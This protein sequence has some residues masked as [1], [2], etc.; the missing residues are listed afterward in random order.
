MIRVAMDG[1]QIESQT[2]VAKRH[3]TAI[4][5]AFDSPERFD[6]WRVGGKTSFD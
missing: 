4:I 3:S 6:V 1:S 5:E 2:Q